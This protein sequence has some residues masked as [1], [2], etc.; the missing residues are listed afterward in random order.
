MTSSHVDA[1]DHSQSH[2]TVSEKSMDFLDRL[3]QQQTLQLQ[4]LVEPGE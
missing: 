4:R 1:D 3:K 2:L